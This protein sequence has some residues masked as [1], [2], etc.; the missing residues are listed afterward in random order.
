M[1]AAMPDAQ[2]RHVGLDELHR[3]VDRQARA[4]TEPPGELM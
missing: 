4:D 1:L 2:R 3:V